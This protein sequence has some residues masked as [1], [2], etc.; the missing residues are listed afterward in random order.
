MSSTEE[1]I[2]RTKEKRLQLER[3]KR[4][5]EKSKKEKEHKVNISRQIIIGKIVLRYFPQILRFQPK[6]TDAEN[7]IEFAP[8][9]DALSVLASDKYF[10]TLK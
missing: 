9:I 5:E 6:R 3:R 10:N 4:A 8:L 1:R 7:E 2:A